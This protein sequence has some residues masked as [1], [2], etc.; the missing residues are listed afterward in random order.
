[1]SPAARIWR[2]LRRDYAFLTGLLVLLVLAGG[3]LLSPWIAQDPEAMD[4]SAIFAPPS[5]E[6][7]LGADELGR[8]VLARLAHGGRISLAVAAATAL[9]AALV[10]T[11]LGLLAGYYGGRLDAVLMRLTDGVMAL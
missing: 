8:D 5:P 1:M 3:A 2:L 4:L 7:W 10:G 9:L 6:H 11:M